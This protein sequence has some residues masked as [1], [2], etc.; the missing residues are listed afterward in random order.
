MDQPNPNLPPPNPQ[1]NAPAPYNNHAQRNAVRS[2]RH[3]A[4]TKFLVI[5][6]S[7]FLLGLLLG[8]L[9]TSL[10]FYFL[11]AEWLSAALKNRKDTIH[12]SMSLRKLCRDSEGGVIERFDAAANA[13]EICACVMGAGFGGFGGGVGGGTLQCARVEL[14]GWGELGSWGEGMG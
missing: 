10:V 8:M 2:P 4:V 13:V 12:R 11:P 6:L 9:S 5:L 7:G 14:A 3:R 1:A